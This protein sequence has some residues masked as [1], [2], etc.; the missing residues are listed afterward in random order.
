MNAKNN[1]LT[2][3][4]IMFYIVYI[5]KKGNKM[6][7]T[8]DIPWRITNKS[9]GDITIQ[10]GAMIVATV[11]HDAGMFRFESEENARLIE[12][13]P[14]MY[15]LLLK[16]NSTIEE[17]DDILKYISRTNRRSAVD[18]PPSL[19]G[20]VP[21][22]DRPST[23][24]TVTSLDEVVPPFNK[25]RQW[26][27]DRNLIKGATVASQSEKLFEENGE[28]VRALLEDNMN[29]FKDAVGDVVVVLTIMC[30][31]KGVNIEDCIVGA[32]EVIKDRKGKMV[33]GVFVKDAE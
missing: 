15:S 3:C 26:A 14:E 19:D 5:N 9:E 20:D 24:E 11:H 18:H 22:V 4:E 16:Y 28:L 21:P 30:A 7:H 10:A 1:Y 17:F 32:Y 6:S 8:I 29:E 31:Q 13:A 12:K 27:S 25:I 23:V 2:P 33:N